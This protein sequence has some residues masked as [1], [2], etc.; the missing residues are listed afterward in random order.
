MNRPSLK[1]LSRLSISVA[2][3]SY[4][5]VCENSFMAAMFFTGILLVSAL[6]AA[7]YRTVDRDKSKL[8]SF[9]DPEEVHIEGR[10]QCCLNHQCKY[11]PYLAILLVDRGMS[12]FY[13]NPKPTWK[14]YCINGRIFPSKPLISHLFFSIRRCRAQRDVN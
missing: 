9:W 2:K 3:T 6:T 4:S 5:K 12:E 8:F 10:A 1:R 11:I 14:L 7:I 13:F